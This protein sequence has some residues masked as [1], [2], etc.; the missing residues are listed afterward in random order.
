MPRS[1]H[2]S[3]L[4][5]T[6]VLALTAYANIAQAA[7]IVTRLNRELQRVMD[8]PAVRERYATLGLEPLKSTPQELGETVKRDLQKWTAFIRERNIKADA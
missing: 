2:T 7:D 4:V 5:A 3:R 6:L 8:L 1:F